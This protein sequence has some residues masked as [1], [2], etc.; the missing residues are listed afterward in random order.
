MSG[1]SSDEGEG[2]LLGGAENGYVTAGA[3]KAALEESAL[4]SSENEQL[5]MRV[6]EL[7]GAGVVD[8]RRG[9]NAARLK[10]DEMG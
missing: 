3:Y 4:L 9:R 2:G 8:A 7:E 6:T 10:K 1:N 5:K